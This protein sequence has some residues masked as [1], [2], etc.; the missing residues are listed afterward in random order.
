MA[1]SKDYNRREFLSKA[2]AGAVTAGLLGVS[3]KALSSPGSEKSFADTDSKFI[4]RTLGNT[5]VK[6]PIVSMGVMNTDNPNL[7]RAGLD[8]GIVHLDTAQAYLEGKSEI[9][10]GEVLKDRPRDS[11]FLSTKILPEWDAT[12]E[13]GN[14]KIS[15]SFTRDIF[16]EKLN[17]SLKNLQMDYIDILYLH[18][19]NNRESA[20]TERLL[21]ALTTAKKQGKIRFAGVSFHENFIELFRAAVESNVYDVILTVYNIQMFGWQE[22]DQVIDEAAKAGLG[23]IAMKTQAGG[24]WDKERQ[25]PINMK[26]ALKWA[27]QNENICTAIPGVTTYDQ[28]SL[29]IS[30]MENLALTPE[31]INDLQ[32]GQ[33]LG[34]TG[35]FC[36]QCRKC[37]EQCRKGLDIPTLM[38]S[39]MY[40]YGYKNPALARNTMQPLGIKDSPCSGCNTCT[41]ECSMGFDVKDRIT[42]IARL[43]NVPKDFLV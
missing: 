13:W 8:A 20:L 26:A 30:I 36:P 12:E 25:H 19:P 40:A 10:V 3:G 1:S 15:D 27:L 14:R 41:V 22:M 32:K 28:L 38:R 33:E 7:I 2:A 5:G 35:L 42:D 43:N 16:L 39:Y 37:I 21:D 18:M 34:M 9:I 6:L 29:D 17:F 31:E 24:Y 23:I 4:Y 11:Y